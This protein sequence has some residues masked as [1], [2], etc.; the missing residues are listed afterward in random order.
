MAMAQFIIPQE[1]KPEEVAEKI[2]F[3]KI[4]ATAEKKKEEESGEEEKKE[5][6]R[7]EKEKK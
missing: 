5:K 3:E 2:D 4:E 1:E 6:K 7:K